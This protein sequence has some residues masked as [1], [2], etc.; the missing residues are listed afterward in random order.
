MSREGRDLEV[1][2]R[3]L[4]GRGLEGPG[5]DAALLRGPGDL[6]LT[7]DPLVEGVHYEPG[8]AVAR[9][10]HKLLHRNLSDLAAMEARPKAIL[11]SFV[12]GSGWTDGER[13]ELYE[14]LARECERVGTRWIGGDLASTKGTTVLTLCA[15]GS[16]AARAPILRSG[17]APGMNLHVSGP[18]GGSLASGRHLDFEAKLALGARLAEHHGPAAMMDLSDGLAL[19]LGRMLRASGGL[20]ARLTEARIPLNHDVKTVDAAL[21]DGEDYELLFALNPSQEVQLS[22]DPEVPEAAKIII[23][24]VVAE[25]GILLLGDQGERIV[26]SETGFEHE[27]S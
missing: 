20:G 27:L 6:L 9:I 13:D 12:F 17:L 14:E 26:V 15:L 11:A 25:P 16:P 22:E 3:L 10:A 5:D 8:T 1:L 21:H 18:L 7:M 4:G 2:A 19:D 23:G 24:E